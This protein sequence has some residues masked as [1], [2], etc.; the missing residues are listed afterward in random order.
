METL[1]QVR[2]NEPK[3]LRA[4]D[5]R[6]PRDLET[7]VLKC[8]EKR[9]P[10]TV[11]LGRGAGRGP[12]T[13]AGR[14]ADPG[15]DRLSDRAAAE[16]GAPPAGTGGG[17]DPRRPVARRHGA[18]GP[19][20]PLGREARVRR[21]ERGEGPG[22]RDAEAD[23]SGNEPGQHGGG[24]VFQA[25]DRGRRRPGSR[26]TPCGP[27]RCWTS[28]RPRFVDGNGTICTGDFHSELQ[29]FRGHD[30]AL[31]AVSFRP[32]GTQF[33]CAAEATG[34]VLWETASGQD[35]RRIPSQNGTSYG[36]AF[37]VAGTRMA[38]AEASGQVRIWDLTTGE[39]S[40]RPAGSRGLGGR[41]GVL[42]RRVDGRVV[43]PGWD[44]PG[45]EPEGKPGERP[46]SA[47][48]GPQ[49][50]RR[51]RLRCRVPSR[52]PGAGL[53]RRR[54]DREDLE[55]GPRG[56]G[57][58]PGPQGPPASGEVRGVSP[59]GEAAGLGR[60]RPDRPG[61][62]RGHGG[63]AGPLRGVRQSRGRDRLQPGRHAD[64][65]GLPGSLG[66]GVGCTQREAG[67]GFPGP[68]RPGVQRDI[69]SRRD[70]ARLGEPGCHGQGLGPDLGAGGTAPVGGS[71]GR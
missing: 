3:R 68:C 44:G 59:G 40:E 65:H 17:R 37:N 4:I 38:S 47:G 61:L 21:R 16:V 26:T 27:T 28:V 7:I 35:T 19:R 18:G 63:R 70:Q 66:P 22:H 10:A 55:A 15:P 39:L 31:C 71:S 9:P 11:P 20:V 67:R 45:L 5:R 57:G 34:F 12:R 29:T 56:R 6:I 32:D 33:A 51:T 23:R 53:G 41:G 69:Q 42:P 14:R 49:G 64:R 43:R 24:D 46:G 48:A 52:R 25:T 58:W 36:L 54:W 60:R 8:L 2:E 50:P 30:G 13:L 1:R 62:G